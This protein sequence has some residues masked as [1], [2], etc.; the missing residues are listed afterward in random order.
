MVRRDLTT[1][2]DVGGGGGR[3]GGGGTG[4]AAAAALPLPIS[5]GALYDL[6]MDVPFFFV[7]AFF[8]NIV[9]RARAGQS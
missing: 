2:F 3:G 9:G 6:E 8:V 7:L 5:R 1:T 4:V